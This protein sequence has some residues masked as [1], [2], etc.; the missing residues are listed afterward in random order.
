MKISRVFIAIYA[1]LL[2]STAIIVPMQ[3]PQPGYDPKSVKLNALAAQNAITL[4]TDMV[5]LRNND[6]PVTEK[7]RREELLMQAQQFSELSQ[8]LKENRL[9]TAWEE[10]RE[11]QLPGEK[12]TLDGRLKEF[13]EAYKD[14]SVPYNRQNIERSEREL[15]ILL[16]S[17]TTT[18]LAKGK[19]TVDQIFRIYSEL[20]TNLKSP[21]IVF[22]VIPTIANLE[23]ALKSLKKLELAQQQKG[24]V[25]GSLVFLTGYQHMKQRLQKKELFSRV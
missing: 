4:L 14:P 23:R 7:Q 1:C 13:L 5:N 6:D 2:I 3:S 22:C 19:I 25:Q 8:L 16:N 18:Q 9:T 11:K 15:G 20:P 21:F 12:N 10:A 24:E 17:L